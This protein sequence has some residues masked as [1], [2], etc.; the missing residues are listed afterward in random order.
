MKTEGVAPSRHPMTAR[1]LKGMLAV[2][3]CLSCALSAPIS[4]DNIGSPT[5]LLRIR[6]PVRDVI[7]SDLRLSFSRA[8]S[9]PPLLVVFLGIGHAVD[10]STKVTYLGALPAQSGTKNYR[11]M[12]SRHELPSWSVEMVAGGFL[13]TSCAGTLHIGATVVAFGDFATLCVGMEAV[14]TTSFFVEL[15]A[16][17]GPWSQI[18]WMQEQ[19]LATTPP[20]LADGSVAGEPP[21]CSDVRVARLVHSAENETTRATF[22]ETVFALVSRLVADA[23][24]EASFAIPFYL[25]IGRSPVSKASKG[26]EHR[27]LEANFLGFSVSPLLPPYD[28]RS[29]A[30]DLDQEGWAGVCTTDS[31]DDL[32]AVKQ[33]RLCEVLI[34]GMSSIARDVIGVLP[35]LVRRCDLAVSPGPESIKL[36]VANGMNEYSLHALVLR[37]KSERRLF[38]EPGGEPASSSFQFHVLWFRGIFHTSTL[39]D[40]VNYIAKCNNAS[41]ERMMPLYSGRNVPSPEFQSAFDLLR[42][43]LDELRD[44]GYRLLHKSCYELVFHVE[45]GSSSPRNPNLAKE[46]VADSPPN[47]PRVIP[48]HPVRTRAWYSTQIPSLSHLSHRMRAGCSPRSLQAMKEARASRGRWILGM[49]SKLHPLLV[50]R[51]LASILASCSKTAPL[52]IVLFVQD[53]DLAAMENVARALAERGQWDRSWA[54]IQFVPFLPHGEERGT[55]IDCA[56]H[57][58]WYSM[59]HAFVA[60]PAGALPTKPTCL[61]TRYLPL[62][63]SADTHALAHTCARAHTLAHRHIRKRTHTHAQTSRHTHSRRHERCFQPP[64]L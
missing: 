38:R 45:P 47:I 31:I 12:L 46:N 64:L 52:H 8:G 3:L 42:S 9:D 57:W 32:L 49:A 56:K 23:N 61:C 35:E 50:R 40:V 34:A 25:E 62:P 2:L 58:Y 21:E 28:W 20:G 60:D 14:V 24:V 30:H 41:L 13:A 39:P 11:V 63:K 51:F 44:A 26:N 19:N 29:G 22:S 17:A 53:V 7:T 5:P 54:S 43:T 4:E 59:L 16:S 36:L 1:C 55:N 27:W 48:N 37:L 15:A 10:P 6:R 33:R 18:G